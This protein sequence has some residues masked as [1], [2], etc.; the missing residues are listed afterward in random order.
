MKK[1]SVSFLSSKSESKDILK[2]NRTSCDFIHVDVMD[3]RFVRKRHKPYK[4]LYRMSSSINKRLDVHLM[5]KK[6]AKYI[7]R[8]ASLNTEYITI[9]V[10]I[11]K[12]DKYIDLIKQYGIK[13]GLAINPETDASILLP[14]LP[15][16]DLILIMSVNPGKGGQPFIEDTYKK[17][18]KIKK[19]IVAKKV[20]IKLSVDGGVNDEVAKKL[21]FVDIIVSGSYVTKSDDFEDAIETIRNNASNKQKSK[22]VKNS[23]E[24]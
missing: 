5:V 23:K 10:E 22:T 6:P 9:P 11:D 3:G 14:Y 21:D 8:F 18:L 17:I 4:M 7:N 2:L 24:E 20:K 12:V 13:C 15:K 1:I 16:I 19:I